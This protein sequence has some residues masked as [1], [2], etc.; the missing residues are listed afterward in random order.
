MIRHRALGTLGVLE[1]LLLAG[2]CGL[3]FSRADPPSVSRPPPG[4]R[5]KSRSKK[6]C[7]FSIKVRLGCVGPQRGASEVVF[8]RTK[9]YIFLFVEAPWPKMAPSG[10]KMAQDDPKMAPRWPQGAP[11]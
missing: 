7:V 11:R 3:Y 2:G 10:P 8:D 4:A 1:C 6:I 9:P 5:R